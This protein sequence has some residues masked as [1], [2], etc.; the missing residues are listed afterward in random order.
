[1]RPSSSRRL[2]VLWLR[3]QASG[4]LI[5]SFCPGFIAAI[6]RRASAAEAAKGFSTTM[7]GPKGAI[8]S[9]YCACAAGAAQRTTRSGFVAL[10]QA[11]TSVKTLSAGIDEVRDRGLHA[12]GIGVADARDL[13]VRVLVHL[14][15]Q[16]AHV[17]VVE[18][19]ADNAKRRHPRGLPPRCGIS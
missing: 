5:A 16:V 17:H 19:D 15:Q 4:Q 9:T 12:L 13:G 8:C 1:M 3:Y 6:I 18:I 2:V 10:R 7:C 11:S 14:A